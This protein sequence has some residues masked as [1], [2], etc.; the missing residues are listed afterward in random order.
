MLIGI[1]LG[2]NLGDRQQYLHH[3]IGEL[4]KL[5]S[6]LRVASFYETDPVDCPPGAA[7]FINTVVLMEYRGD[8]LALLYS[9]QNL[10]QLA[11]RMDE[12]IRQKNAPRPLDLDILFCDDQVRADPELILPH[13]RMMDRL[14]VLEPLAE[15]VP[16][17]H[18]YPDRPSVAER[19]E[20]LKQA[21]NP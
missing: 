16:D 20:E 6:H 1:G 15:L 8:L 4:E 3:A 2:S 9:L 19:V 10:E 12:S 21:P 11:G 14:F 5:G 13:P 18:P 7:T 17:F